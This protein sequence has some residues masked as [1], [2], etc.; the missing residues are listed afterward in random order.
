MRHGVAA[1]MLT[2][3]DA[4]WLQD[5]FPTLT[6][7]NDE[8]AGS[9]KFIATY[10]F[11]S[12]KFLLIETDTVDDVGGVRLL[13]EFEIHIKPR[14]IKTFSNLPAL[15]IANLDRDAERHIN[16][17]DGT[18]CLCSPFEEEEFLLPEF[19]FIKFFEHLIV[20]F[21]YG[22]AFYSLEGKWPWNDYSHGAVGLLE[23]Y[24]FIADQSMAKECLDKLSKGLD[25]PDI[26]RI[27]TSK[28]IDGHIPCLCSKKD[29]IRRCHPTA[30]RGIKRLKS[31]LINQN[32]PLP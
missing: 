15:S 27:L 3:K 19:N 20:P 6:V 21:L 14:A 10:N 11:E 29:Q 2:S 26:K 13:A 7:S 25:W 22:Q 30:F 23:S 1:N 28:D 9:I 5:K 18:A 16:M 17:N 24:Y 12:N 31:D 4:R 32:I 8:V